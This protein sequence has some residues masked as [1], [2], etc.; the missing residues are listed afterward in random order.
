[1][2]TITKKQKADLDYMNRKVKNIDK[3]AAINRRE[4]EKLEKTRVVRRK[5]TLETIKKSFLRQ[6]NYIMLPNLTK[7]LEKDITGEE[8][9]LLTN[10]WMNDARD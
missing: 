1:M 10:Q 4:D 2:E 9:D 7:V 5:N 3:Y 6:P 8:I